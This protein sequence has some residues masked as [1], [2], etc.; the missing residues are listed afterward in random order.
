MISS[1]RTV[2]LPLLCCAVLHACSEADSDPPSVTILEPAE[3]VSFAVFDTVQVTYEVSDDRAVESVT[4]KLVNQ[5]FI[6]VTGQVSRTVGANAFTGTSLL[7]IDNR[8][9]ESG[10]YYIL[11]TATDGTNDRNAFR[12]VHVAAHPFAR[13]AL[14]FADVNSSGQSGV[15]RVDSLFSGV[16]SFLQ[17][18][19]D[20]GRVTV[21]SDRDRVTV[22][23]IRGTGIMQF[24]L[25]VSGQRWA[26]SANNQP[27]APT[28][29]DMVT[30]GANLFVSL[31][32]R[33]VR[34]YAVDGA[35]ILNRQFDSDRPHT[36]YA[37]EAHLLVELREIGG[38]QNRLL[39]LRQNNFSE[40]WMVTLPMRI[41][42]ICRRSADELLIFGNDG[43]Q[44]RVI[45]YNTA[46]NGWWEPRQLPPG[47]IH[48]A[49]KGEGQ[50]FFLALQSGLYAYTYSPNYLNAIR[51]GKVFQRLCFDRSDGLVIGATGSAIEVISSP[52]GNLLAQ[53]NHTDSITDLDIRYTK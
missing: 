2:L 28:F 46:T 31:Y 3:N 6:P 20:V 17:P 32:T 10:R 40:K 37:D 43:G 29:H 26:T 34:G 35:L 9:L 39:V 52:Q 1:L 24:G 22:A 16:S 15:Y 8:Q 30:N 11:V 12:E 38:A 14:F 36:L 25:D 49:V 7:V 53:V 19:Q 45:L 5:D 47:V 27:P 41:V 44:A 23:G 13:R 50:T 42:A 18:G 4:V 33:E 21:H 48:H 51:S